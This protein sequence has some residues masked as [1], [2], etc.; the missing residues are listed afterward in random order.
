MPPSLPRFVPIGEDTTRFVRLEDLIAAEMGTLFPG[1]TVESIHPFRVTRNAD[2]DLDGS[3]AEHLLM[4][5]ESE[6]R[7]RRFGRA[8]RLEVAANMPDDTLA[9][10]IDELDLEPGDVT[11]THGWLGLGSLWSLARIERPD[12]RY[13]PWMAIVPRRLGGDIAPA[14]M[15][16]VIR[17]GDL[18]VHHPYDSFSATVERFIAEAADDPKVLAI[19]LTLYRTSGDGQIVESLIRAVG[20]GK[21]GR[22]ACTSAW[23]RSLPASTRT[24]RVDQG[25]S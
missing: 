4:A 16:A 3:D 22:S 24:P 9:L 7:R 23:S 8:V 12:L 21:T 2:I 18:L 6:L 13:E 10:L 1:L 15:F 19:K 20:A 17:A 14:D 11:R 5:V 25:G